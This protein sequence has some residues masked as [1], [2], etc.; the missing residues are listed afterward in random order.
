[1]PEK[2]KFYTGQIAWIGF[3]LSFVEL[4]RDEWSIGE[5]GYTFK[6]MLSFA[7]DGITAFSDAPLKLASTLGFL[8]SGF[9][10][11]VIL[12]TLYSN[13]IL[14]QTISGWTSLIISFMFISGV[15]LL[16]L[17]NWWMY[18]SSYR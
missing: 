2:S 3:K 1:M 14:N 10:F 16:A 9:S 5:T 12:Y 13:F 7:F 15:Q 6:K 8:V 11:V 18:Q 4:H 17:G